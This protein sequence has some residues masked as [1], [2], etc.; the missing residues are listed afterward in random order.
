MQENETQV[1]PI[2]IE[3]EMRVSYLDYA[4]SVIAGRALPDVRDG[5]KPVHR[6]ILYAMY[7]LGL[8]WKKPFKKS[9]RVV[10]EVLGKYHPHGD[11]AVYDALTR[12]V[13]DFSLRYPLV[14]GQGNFGSM[15]GDSPAAMRYTEVRL[16]TITEQLLLD[17]DK[18]TVSYS[19][20]FDESLEEPNVLPAKLPNLL[21]NGS[22]GIAV[23]MAT[24][25]PPHNLG[26]IIAGAV[27]L[28]DNPHTEISEL[29]EVIKGPD[30]PTGALIYGY[31]G[32]RDGFTTGRG[33]VQVRAK[34]AIEEHKDRGRIVITEI[35]YQ[36][37]KARLVEKI[38]ELVKEKKLEGIA[39][40]R[41][42]SD[43]DGTRV[44][45]DLKRNEIAQVILN[46]L[47]KHTPMQ[48]TFGVNMLAIVDKRPRLLTLKDA[49][50]LYIKHRRDVVQRRTR[51]EL[52]KAEAR[53][54]ILKGLKIAL[55]NLDEV[56]ALIKKAASPR[57]A[58]DGLMERFG[59]SKIQA[60]AILE[61]RLQRLTAME[62]NK[63]HDEH[64]KL[65][66]EIA[67][68]QAILEND[69]LLMNI[70]KEELLE[71]KEKYADTRRT[72][73]IPMEAELSL[74]DLI[75]DEDVVIVITHQGYIKRN[76][77]RLY[78]LQK[79]SGHGMRGV[80]TK[81]TDFVEHLFVC[82]THSYLLVFTDTGRIHWLKVYKVPEAGRQAKGLPIVNL[83]PLGPEEKITAVI[84]IKEFCEDKFL[85]MATKE[86]T[87]KKSPLS[88]YSNPRTGGII[89][90]SLKEN[91]RLISVKLSSGNQ[92]VFLGTR[93]GR[94]I[95][96]KEADVRSIGRVG[97]GVR[98][99]RLMAQDEVIG[100]EIVDVDSTILTV[101]ENG[102]GKQTRLKKYPTIHRGGSGVIN[103]KI[104]KKNGAVVGIKQTSSD[105]T[106]MLITANGTIIWMATNEISVIGRSTQGVK[107][108]NLA[109]NDKVVAVAH[110]IEEKDED[111][112]E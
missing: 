31:K 102:Y 37:N 32:I 3:D 60:Q 105:D 89:A 97:Q 100:M 17:I 90:I 56:I 33:L 51:F 55:D 14:D 54:H 62:Q 58:N 29:M 78:R 69:A 35:P 27:M 79:R 75:V 53:V 63:I 12:M 48:T 41:D 52:N 1:L 66:M 68:L 86:G 11:M 112:E 87:I 108:Q 4:M 39:D 24:N 111:I 8:L 93:L 20:N 47:Y 45:I 22:S 57:D 40:L 84:P 73:I 106:I 23:G 76:P 92:D 10:G 70:I 5:L 19:P 64:T 91:D 110:L 82:S 104:T 36:V 18:D 67:R 103:I 46:K 96:F 101:T 99:I 107:L 21:I 43:R 109:E 74:E 26:E 25:I 49:L 61:M 80:T 6:R 85:V 28:I 71:I 77:L 30:F 50:L 7:E 42:E 38:A 16:A 98:G 44:V 34:A 15:D 83:L 95:H 9:A 2:N 65:L 59:L 88:E 72:A 94:G 81:E 13:Q